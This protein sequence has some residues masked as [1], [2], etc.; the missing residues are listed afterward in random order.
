M[1]SSWSGR[2]V[3]HAVNPSGLKLGMAR[4]SLFVPSAASADN[5]APEH[6]RA[7][8]TP[9]TNLAIALSSYFCRSMPRNSW[10][11]AG[12][13]S[14][15]DEIV[16][17]HRLAELRPTAR[18]PDVD[19]ANRAREGFEALELAHRGVGRVPEPSG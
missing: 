18:P 13:A 3:V 5:S 16:R 14:I 6:S 7:A 1:K 15:A 17:P 12:P 2:L 19:E 8:V 9:T 11:K 10:A 4:P